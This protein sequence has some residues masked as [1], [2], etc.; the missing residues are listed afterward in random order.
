[1][2]GEKILITEDDRLLAL[3][4]KR[5]LESQGY[6]I[7]GTPSRGEESISIAKEYKP[8]II[9]MDIKL[10]G[11]MDGIQTAKQI[12]K[13][14]NIPCIYLTAYAD[15]ATLKKAIMTN[16]LGYLVKPFKDDELFATIEMVL[17]KNRQE[18]LRSQQDEETKQ[19][20]EN[21]EKKV[22][23]YALSIEQSNEALHNLLKETH[24]RV[25]NNLQ[26]ISSLLQLQSKSIKDKK[27]RMAL[28]E[29]RNR[30][31]SIGLV[32]EILFTS[33]KIEKISLNNY[34]KMLI[35]EIYISHGVSIENVSIEILSDE[36]EINH[37][38][39]ISCGLIINELVS[40][41]FKHAFPN[42]RKGKIFIKFKE[43]N[44]NEIELTVVDNGVGI[45][46]KKMN[47]IYES[48]G[49]Q[50]VKTLAEIQLGGK[51]EILS[52]EGTQIAILFNVNN[53]WGN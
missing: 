25:K 37:N 51:I 8:D 10:R 4:L 6:R 46:K 34:I 42:N 13:H 15:K 23:L 28:Q 36:F 47:K 7:V 45:P 49:L 30:I 29:S 27:A 1:M 14:L 18:K 19:Y 11:K 38:L 3:G 12:N 43:V 26:I 33:E 31:K 22:N 35:D 32:H 41:C 44:S 40:N 24:H 5:I 50:L 16:P 53:E 21:L 52:T 48:L 39:V 20:V 9:I 2:S 17:H